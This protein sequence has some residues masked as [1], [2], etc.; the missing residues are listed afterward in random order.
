MKMPFSWHWHRFWEWADGHLATGL[1]TWG[2]HHHNRSDAHGDLADRI[3]V[4]RRLKAAPEWNPRLW[5]RDEDP[6]SDTR[7][8]RP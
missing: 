5:Q 6:R 1:W 2:D 7:E 8:R 3:E 4:R